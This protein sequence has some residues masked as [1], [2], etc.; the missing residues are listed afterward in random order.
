MSKLKTRI[1][2]WMQNVREMVYILR[3]S[4]E[5]LTLEVVLAISLII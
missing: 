5:A 4:L 1:L 2:K 3:F